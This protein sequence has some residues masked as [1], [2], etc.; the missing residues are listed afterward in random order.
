MARRPRGR[1]GASLPASTK[2]ASASK[3]H[4]RVTDA[5]TER[6][7]KRFRPGTVPLLE[8]RNYQKSGELLIPRQ[9]FQRLVKEIAAPIF[10]LRFRPC[11]VDALQ[12]AAE[13][14]LISL[15]RDT[16]EI[17]L[18]G[19]RQTITREDMRVARRL[20]ERSMMLHQ[21]GGYPYSAVRG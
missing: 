18:H 3:R 20:T 9:P 15:L 19:K 17:A 6:R 13:N 21:G 5:A 4:G 16:N 8:I 7:K 2:K 11:A 12:E 10:K 1:S 14:H